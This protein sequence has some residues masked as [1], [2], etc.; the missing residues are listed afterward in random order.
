MKMSI[1]KL[2]YLFLNIVIVTFPLGQIGR[3]FFYVGASRITVFPSD[4]LIPLILFFWIMKKTNKDLRIRFKK[5]PLNVPIILFAV[6]C[7]I[8]LLFSTL[9]FE[10]NKVIIGSLYA[11]RWILFASL[12]FVIVDLFKDLKE[13]HKYIRLILYIGIVVAVLG[14]LQLIFLPDMRTF[15]TKLAGGG[16]DLHQN[17]MV[18]TFLDPNFLGGYFVFLSSIALSCY[19]FIKK[20]TENANV[21]K[22]YIFSSILFVGC[23][24]LTFS[25]ATFMA[26]VFVVA[27]LCLKSIYKRKT[28]VIKSKA[29]RILIFSLGAFCLMLPK[30][31]SKFSAS[32]VATKI[33]FVVDSSASARLTTWMQA[34]GII[35]NDV[36]SFLIGIGYN[37]YAFARGNII[38]AGST[39]PQNSLLFIWATTGTIGLAIYCLLLYAIIRYCGSIAKSNNY[40]EELKAV[41][42]GYKV[43]LI[44]L[45][46][47]SMFID[48][49]TYAFIMET[50]WIILGL[51]TAWQFAEKKQLIAKQEVL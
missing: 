36:L 39:G 43:G 25:R 50:M 14:V 33:G 35:F 9:R 29:L 24:A 22:F 6:I 44:A 27:A 20:N 51:I 34:F 10:I 16:W 15:A 12:F 37:N 19:V 42:F 32:P 40:S 2:I 41:A 47:H 26:F 8:S 11:I 31:I 38:K 7:I 49:L 46:V 13:I 18:S 23:M 5:T 28:F 4:I 21:F 45:V 48:S 17:R 1:R 30:I 3:L